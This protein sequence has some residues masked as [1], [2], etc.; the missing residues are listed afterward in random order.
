MEPRGRRRKA[1]A[2]GFGTV[3]FVDEITGSIRPSRM[4]SFHL[5]EK[6]SIVPTAPL[7][8]ILLEVNAALLLSR[9]R[10]PVLKA[11][12]EEMDLVKY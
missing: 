9:C 3:L 6:G 8:R 1:A 2:W 4:P 5:R 7:Q 11:L 10:V 12:E